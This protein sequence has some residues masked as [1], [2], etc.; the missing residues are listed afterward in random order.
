MTKKLKISKQAYKIF[1]SMEDR[2]CELWNKLTS[3]NYNL[4]TQPAYELGFLCDIDDCLKKM[5]VK[6]T[7]ASK[8]EK[9]AKE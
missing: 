9:V 6:R 2:Y 3:G 5:R 7:F 8:T 4:A 1:D